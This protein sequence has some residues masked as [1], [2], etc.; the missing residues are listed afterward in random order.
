MLCF[1]SDCVLL[2]C[3]VYIAMCLVVSLV[4]V[5]VLSNIDVDLFHSYL[6]IDRFW[7]SERCVCVR[8]D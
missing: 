8:E 3:T 2:S 4:C 5:L 6:S 1:V 7:I